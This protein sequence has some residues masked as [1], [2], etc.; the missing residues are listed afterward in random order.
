MARLYEPPISHLFVLNY[1]GTAITSR[2]RDACTCV[3]EDIESH[4]I[5]FEDESGKIEVTFQKDGLVNNRD[6]FFLHHK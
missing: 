2:S 1:V 4:L 6:R 3:Q 5:D